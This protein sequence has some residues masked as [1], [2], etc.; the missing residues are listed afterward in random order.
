MH[1][2]LLR[3]LREKYKRAS[4]KY[5]DKI[6]SMKELEN[7]IRHLLVTKGNFE[8]FI[9]AEMEFYEKAMGI[10]KTREAEIQR[11]NEAS[12]KIDAILEKNLEKIKKY[13]ESYFDPAASVE[14]RKMVGAV[15]DW[16]EI[17]IPLIKH[18]YRGS[19]I[20][21]DISI[22]QA[23]IERLYIPAGRPITVFLKHYVDDIKKMALDQKENIERR[24]LQTCANSLYKMENL[25]RNESA[26]MSDFQKSRLIS[27]SSSYD[28]GVREK[29][30]KKKE[31]D[32]LLEIITNISVIIDDF[33]LR[34]LSALG[35]KTAENK[36]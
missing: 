23:E 18:L 30:A 3:Q 31:Y 29:W 12:A 20:W 24:L 6:F 1:D 33:R 2:D 11:K 17:S 22:L 35:F 16:Y 28:N 13:R 19:D 25:L 4:E 21:N 32:A 36:K 14:V 5:G 34:D 7:R 27:M 10:V 26:K 9:K 8:I 15:S